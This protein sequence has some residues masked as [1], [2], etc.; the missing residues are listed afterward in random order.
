MQML[1]V[2]DS[3]KKFKLQYSQQKYE[4]TLKNSTLSELLSYVDGYYRVEINESSILI[5][6]YTLNGFFPLNLVEIANINESE[7]GLEIK[8]KD[9]EN[10]LYKPILPDFIKSRE[11]ILNSM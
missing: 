7:K 8:L 2:S 4:I 9:V 6:S 3:F 1:N 5:L 10:L 11:K